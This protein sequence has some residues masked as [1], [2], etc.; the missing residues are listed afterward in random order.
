[1]DINNLRTLAM[2]T[3]IMTNGAAEAGKQLN[4]LQETLMLTQNAARIQEGM[5]DIQAQAVAKLMGVGNKID[6]TV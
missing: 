2:Y 1:M 6:T 3:D 5:A 4:R